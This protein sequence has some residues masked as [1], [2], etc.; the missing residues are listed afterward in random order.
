MVTANAVQASS[1]R[2]AIAV[3][4][5]SA[6]SFASGPTH[7][8]GHA[9]NPSL[10]QA[11]RLVDPSGYFEIIIEPLDVHDLPTLEVD[12][13]HGEMRLVIGDESQ[14]ETFNLFE[15][16]A[17]L[18]QL[19]IDLHVPRVRVSSSMIGLP[20]VFILK[21]ARGTAIAAPFRPDCA[22]GLALGPIDVEAAADVL[23]WGHPIA[24]RTLAANLRLAPV[25]SIVE[26][27]QAGLLEAKPLPSA[28]SD[29]EIGADSTAIIELQIAAFIRAA[30]RFNL[31]RAFLTLSGGLDSRA[32]A[33][34][35]LAAGRAVPCITLAQNGRSLDARLAAAFCQ[36]HDLEHRLI[37]IG[38]EF[39]RGLPERVL[40]SAE[41]TL[42]V[43]AISQTVD[44]YLYEQM[45]AHFRRRISGNLGNQVGRGGVEGTKSIAHANGILSPELQRALSTRPL[46]PWFVRRMQSNGFARTLFTQEV[47]YWSIANY[48]LSSSHAVQ[49][50]PYADRH[51]IRLSAQLFA[52]LADFR[53]P[54]TQ[55]IR[56]RDLRHR[57]FGPPFDKSFQRQ[58]L[59]EF[60]L[61]GARVALNWGWLARGGWSP[62]WLL[63]ALPTVASAAL[64]KVAPSFERARRVMPPFELADWAS[65][66]K[67]NLRD[68]AYD[69]LSSEAVR[70]SGLF[71]NA[72]LRCL[73]DR[74]FGDTES[75]YATVARAL[76]VGLACPLIARSNT[77]RGTS[78]I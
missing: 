25:N 7:P 76:E 17:N 75:R 2:C 65:V 42:G 18:V 41:L 63:T 31:S 21:S 9:A 48:V 24:N 52:S 50:T 35:T 23:R 38:Q 64:S 3:K 22:H 66:L 43:S 27:G 10:T 6:A 4:R 44:L 54:T 37:V 45:G 69:V 55:S 1:S 59:L 74:H 77:S 47:T 70:T 29:F 56:Q 61:R 51:L 12:A 49:L 33:V 32:V 34:A 19:E 14:L 13:R 11:L 71:D 36:A 57:L 26:L 78:A 20:P 39:R 5:F 72:A 67:E 53:A 68:L 30:A 58:F 46:E 73:L 60:D 62:K 28:E 16:H 8:A 40:R 15:S